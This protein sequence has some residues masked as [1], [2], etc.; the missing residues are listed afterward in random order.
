MTWDTIGTA[1]ICIL[2]DN[3]L[4]KSDD[5]QT[6]PKHVADVTSCTITTVNCVV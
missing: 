5:G 6:K 3:N 2:I 1:T 4:C